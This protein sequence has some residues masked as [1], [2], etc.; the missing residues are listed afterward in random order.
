QPSQEER[1]VRLPERLH[2]K[3][4]QP[5]RHHTQLEHGDENCRADALTIPPRR[6]TIAASTISEGSR[7]P[8]CPTRGSSPSSDRPGRRAGEPPAPSPPTPRDHSRP[9]PS[10]AKSTATRRKRSAG[11]QKSSRPIWTTRRA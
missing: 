3:G 1:H 7:R 9:A 11:R 8:T 5:L 2:R 4:I 6:S 10:R